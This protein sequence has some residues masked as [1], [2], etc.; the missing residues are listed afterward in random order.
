MFQSLIDYWWPQETDDNHSLMIKH[1]SNEPVSRIK[2]FVEFTQERY[3][4]LT[5][6]DLKCLRIRFHKVHRQLVVNPQFRGQ[7]LS[8]KFLAARLT[9]NSVNDLD[10]QE[11]AKSNEIWNRLSEL[12][13]FD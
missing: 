9:G 8:W 4:D 12:L 3:P 13:K 5:Q 2:R 11:L 1:V 10:Q 6:R 7:H